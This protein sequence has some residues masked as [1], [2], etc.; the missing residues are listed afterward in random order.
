M[1]I[2][3]LIL[4]GFIGNFIACNEFYCN[5]HKTNDTGYKWNRNYNP[6][7]LK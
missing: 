1:I 4:V 3:S 6:S 2:L 7:F 5:K